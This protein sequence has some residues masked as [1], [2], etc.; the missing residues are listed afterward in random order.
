MDYLSNTWNSLAGMLPGLIKGILLVLVAWLIATLVR[1]GIRKG[2]AAMNFEERLTDWGAVN[3]A[4]QG[5]GMI[6]TLAQVFYYLVWVLFL[7][8][9]FETFGLTSVSMPIQNMLD[10]AL[11]FLPNLIA[12]IAL[13]VIAVIVGKFV[14]NLV[15][16]LALSLNV[17]RWISKLTGQDSK[18]DVSEGV[19]TEEKIQLRM[20]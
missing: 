4:E 1:T 15:Y 7:P 16:N 17:D 19:S 3:S 14:K 18:T 11:S 12:A 9:I 5:K 6:D 13:V 20:Y 2:L 10:T 8:G